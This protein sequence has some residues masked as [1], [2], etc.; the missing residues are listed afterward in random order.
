MCANGFVEA[1]VAALVEQV[2]ILVGEKRER[3]SRRWHGG[4]RHFP[5][6]IVYRK[7]SDATG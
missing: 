5:E 1:I 7:M 2:E 3:V 4:F 6:L